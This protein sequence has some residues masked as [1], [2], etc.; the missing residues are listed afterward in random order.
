LDEALKYL[1]EKKKRLS[2]HIV[3]VRDFVSR[4]YHEIAHTYPEIV[5]SR[6]PH[7]TYG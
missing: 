6:F 5:K 2:G 7:V 1:E 4:V 3:T